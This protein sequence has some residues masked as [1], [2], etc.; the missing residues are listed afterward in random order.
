MRSHLKILCSDAYT[1][2]IKALYQGG[3]PLCRLCTGYPRGSTENEN[4]THIVTQCDAYSDLRSRILHQMEL[5]FAS[6]KTKINFKQMLSNNRELCQFIH[7]CTSLN[8][9]TRISEE[10]DICPRLFVL[11]C[12]LRHGIS[13]LRSQK[14]KLIKEFCFYRNP[15]IIMVGR[16]NF[17]LINSIVSPEGG[18]VGDPK[19]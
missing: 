12:D 16:L 13:K 18:L 8:L 15:D 2:E 19:H 4:I 6:A 17:G 9:P 7:E 11:S 5:I 3:S 1:Y 14:L 10:D